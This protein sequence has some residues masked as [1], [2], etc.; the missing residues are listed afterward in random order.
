MHDAGDSIRIEKLMVV[1]FDF[2]FLYPSFSYLEISSFLLVR[3]L[4]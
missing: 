2:S 3:F 1:Y 4:S